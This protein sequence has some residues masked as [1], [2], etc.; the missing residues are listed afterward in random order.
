MK[1][2]VRLTESDLARIVRRVL[3]EQPVELEPLEKPTTQ[4]T[5]SER[6]AELKLQDEQIK[7]LEDNVKV[8][9]REI[10]QARV[11]NI[12]EKKDKFVNFIKKTISSIDEKIDNIKSEKNIEKVYELKQKQ[13][14]LEEKLRRIE[15]GEGRTPEEKEDIILTLK[16]VAADLVVNIAGLSLLMK[17]DKNKFN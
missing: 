14:R 17:K 8:I 15:T 7:K 1:K 10:R 9:N 2:I 4:K 6:T 12:L 5:S 3:N 16:M 13:I 11:D